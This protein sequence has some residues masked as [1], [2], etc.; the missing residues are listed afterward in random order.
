LTA[1]ALRIQAIGANGTIRQTIASTGSG[2]VFSVWIRR[3]SGTGNIQLSLNNSTY[4]TLSGVTSTWKRFHIS[5]AS[6]HTIP[7]IRVVALN[8]TIEIWGAQVEIYQTSGVA[9]GA[10]TPTSYIKTTT[11]GASRAMDFLYGNSGPSFY[12]Q[13]NNG[14]S[15]FLKFRGRP[16]SPSTNSGT[17]FYFENSS[18]EGWG[19][20]SGRNYYASTSNAITTGC[21]FNAAIFSINSGNFFPSSGSV[22]SDFTSVFTLSKNEAKS[23][24]TGSGSPGTIVKGSSVTD[25]TP[26]DLVMMPLFNDSSI[27][28]PMTLQ[29]IEVWN[30]ALTDS[31]M[32]DLIP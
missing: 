31:Q 27:V 13:L 24:T 21:S 22:L 15:V 6:S 30:Y 23:L 10:A 19:A 14:N 4:T 28:I 3:V 12:A 8:D 26:S 16:S 29:R 32:K 20:D 18:A 2:R 5:A 25:L 9:T 7:S 17:F 11:T 1:T